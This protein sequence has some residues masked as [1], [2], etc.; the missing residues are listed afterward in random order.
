MIRCISLL[1]S[2]IITVN[3]G[4]MYAVNNEPVKQPEII[5]EEITE[6]IIEPSPVVDIYEEPVEEDVPEEPEYEV[7]LTDDEIDL[8][9]LVTMAEAEGECVE[10]KRLVIDVI[11]NRLE[12]SRFDDTVHD[13]VYASGA[14]SSMWNGRVDRCYVMDEIRQLV[15]E[16]LQSRTNYEV[17]YFRTKHYHKFGTPVVQVGN[18]YFST[19]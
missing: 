5:Y 12:S 4:T 16:E 14:F 18:H 3:S 6:E 13:V 17:L 9:A 2:V 19:Y 1:I 11:L 10:G 15:V 8:I 7:Y